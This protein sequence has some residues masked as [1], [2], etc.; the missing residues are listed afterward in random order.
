MLHSVFSFSVLL[1]CSKS[2]TP[3]VSVLVRIVYVHNPVV[4]I[5]VVEFRL[6]ILVLAEE[7]KI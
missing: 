3:S 6:G 2:R 4:T 7:H 1:V 5:N